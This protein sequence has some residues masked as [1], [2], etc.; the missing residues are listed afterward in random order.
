MYRKAK[1]EVCGESYGDLNPSN[2][3]G[4]EEWIQTADTHEKKWN[5]CSL[6]S[7]A[8]KSMNGKMVY[9]RNA[10]ITVNIAE[11]QQP[12]MRKQFA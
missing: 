11:A 1:C 3:T 12:V 5:C 2:H 8:K 7:V 6:V 9:V 10:A 4:T